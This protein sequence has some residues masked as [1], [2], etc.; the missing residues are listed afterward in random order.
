M[1]SNEDIIVLLLR[2]GVVIVQKYS[3]N[4][5]NTTKL[6]LNIGNIFAYN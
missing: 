6:E 1:G 2:C 3:Y 4:A 5:H